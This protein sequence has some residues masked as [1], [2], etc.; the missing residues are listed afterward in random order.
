MDSLPSLVTI[1]ALIG[2][3]PRVMNAENVIFGNFVSDCLSQNSQQSPGARPNG[4]WGVPHRQSYLPSAG[5]VSLKSQ[6]VTAPCMMH[7]LRS[8]GRGVPCRAVQ[9]LPVELARIVGTD[10]HTHA[11]TH[12]HTH[13]RTH[14]RTHTHTMSQTRCKASY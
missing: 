4:S 12:T 2:A 5:R 14:A 3:C 1:G 8:R 6:G 11:H 13:A 10:T 9:R 7:V